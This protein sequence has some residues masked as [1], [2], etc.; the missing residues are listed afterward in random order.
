MVGLKGLEQPM[1]RRLRQ[2]RRIRQL[3]HTKRAALTT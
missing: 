2:R 3:S 1:D